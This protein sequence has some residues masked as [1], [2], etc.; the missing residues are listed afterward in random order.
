MHESAGTRRKTTSVNSKVSNVQKQKNYWTN[1]SS[2]WIKKATSAVA[3]RDIFTLRL[4]QE[5]GI[6]PAMD[7]LDVA[8]GTGDPAITIAEKLK[9][10]NVIAYDITTEM[11]SVAAARANKLILTNM[12][13]I[14]GNMAALPFPNNTFDAVTS[15]NGIMFPDDKLQCAREALRV[16]RPGRKAGWLVWG[17]IESNPTF[18]AINTG[19]ETFFGEK[20]RPRMIRHSLGKSGLLKNIIQQAGFAKAE[21]IELKKERI[22]S[23][24]DSF[25]RRAIERAVPDKIGA[26]SETDWS[27][28]LKTVENSCS[29]H[30]KGDILKIPIVMRLGIGTSP[31]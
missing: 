15:R 6:T 26:L 23:Q 9:S 19:L 8:S 10:G 13:M 22:I 12:H 16:L 21:E 27:E 28:L 4:I 11:L 5:V 2:S 29:D 31:A 25:F 20:F 7:V 14:T 18:L 30:L 24:E 17:E 1:R 3:S